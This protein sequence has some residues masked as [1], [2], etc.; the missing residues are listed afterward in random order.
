MCKLYI[1]IGY[2]KT[3]TTTMQRCVFDPLHRSGEIFYLGMFGFENDVT[4]ARRDFFNDVTGAMYLATSDFDAILP[5][6]RLQLGHLLEGVD[7]TKPVV[8]SNEHFAQSQDSTKTDGLQIA[9]SET[10]SRLAQVFDGHEIGIMVCL[11]RQDNL[12]QAL[13][14]EHY[15]RPN[16]KAFAHF[17]GLNGFTKKVTDR[18][19]LLSQ[20]F[21]FDRVMYH[22][23]MSFPSSRTLVWLF[24]EFCDDNSRILRQMFDFIKIHCGDDDAAMTL[25]RLNMKTGR[26]G[27]VSPTTKRLVRLIFPG[28]LLAII[29]KNSWMKNRAERL[30]RSRE[31]VTMSVQE[32]EVIRRFWSDSNRALLRRHPH[33]QGAMR[34]YGY[35]DSEPDKAREA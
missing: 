30:L 10:F 33:L 28:A 27:H 31:V 2:P 19:N 21:D 14:L 16:N 9:P 35:F 13:F 5:K 15:S 32:K 18:S 1:H 8:L 11:R 24:E 25:D 23:Q 17:G 29:S 7:D 12:A 26:A 4:G 20:A 3:G 6:L 34:R 22:V